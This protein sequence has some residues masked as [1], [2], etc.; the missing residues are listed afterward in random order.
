MDKMAMGNS[1]GSLW[2]TLT[3]GVGATWWNSSLLDIF[4]YLQVE[5]PLH[6]FIFSKLT[7]DL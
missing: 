1:G 6:V 7:I 5:S 2:S 4:H 3:Q